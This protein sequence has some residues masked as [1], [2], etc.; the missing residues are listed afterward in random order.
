M[1]YIKSKCSLRFLVPATC[2]LLLFVLKYVTEIISRGRF[3]FPG[4]LES[5]ILD[6]MLCFVCVMAVLFFPFRSI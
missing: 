6:K 5:E 4:N 2:Y 1:R 3:L